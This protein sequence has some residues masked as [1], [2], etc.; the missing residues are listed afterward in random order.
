VVELEVV[1]DILFD[2]HI[3]NIRF[4][5]VQE[6]SFEDLFWEPST[7]NAS[8]ADIWCDEIVGNGDIAVVFISLKHLAKLAMEIGRRVFGPSQAVLAIQV[9]LVSQLHSHKSR[10][11][12]FLTE[13]RKNVSSSMLG[14]VV[15]NRGTHTGGC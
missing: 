10:A 13:F 8:A 12:N 3:F 7:S 15:R 5:G 2:R 4:I 1:V 9:W 6:P 14:F 11:Q